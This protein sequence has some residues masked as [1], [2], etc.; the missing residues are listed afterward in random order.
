MKQG[1]KHNGKQLTFI[2]DW[3]CLFAHNSVHRK[4]CFMSIAIC[5]RRS[6]EVFKRLASVLIDSKVELHLFLEELRL[7]FWGFVL[8]L[9]S[10][11]ILVLK[12]N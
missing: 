2:V 12:P 1:N 8:H 3:F 7:N 6:A 11:P 9:I 4:H 5:I 10:N